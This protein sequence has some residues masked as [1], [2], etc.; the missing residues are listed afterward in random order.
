[1]AEDTVS[2]TQCRKGRGRPYKHEYDPPTEIREVPGL[3]KSSDSTCADT[4]RGTKAELLAMGLLQAHQFPGEPGM[5]IAS[6]TLWPAGTPP[7]SSWR[8][9]G[10]VTVNRNPSGHFTLALVVPEDEQQRRQALA[11][12]ERAARDAEWEATK[13]VREAERRAGTSLEQII[14]D[15]GLP[16]VVARVE[17]L[18]RQTRSPR[19]AAHLRL[20]WSAPGA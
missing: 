8:T 16:A 17:R 4:Y 1:M 18:R 14:Q 10:R 3:R 6:V 9:P 11:D 20:V 7:G 19:P 12:A 2:P 15:L 13:R 5:P